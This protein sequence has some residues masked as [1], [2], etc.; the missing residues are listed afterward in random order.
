M[1]LIDSIRRRFE[2]LS[3]YPDER[4]LRLFAV[5]GTLPPGRGGVSL[6]ATATGVARSTICCGL[7]ELGEEPGALGRV[8]RPGG[9]RKLAREVQDGLGEAL[10][11]LMGPVVCGDPGH[12][13][14]W[15][16]KSL[17]HLAAALSEQGLSV[18]H[19]LVDPGLGSLWARKR[20]GFN[21]SD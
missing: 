15:V 9:G 6:I 8:Y 21:N 7:A 14:R 5:S 4:G 11:A 20:A 1:D 19:T 12:P 17:R 13:L 18:S 2:A 16:S 10:D 3:P